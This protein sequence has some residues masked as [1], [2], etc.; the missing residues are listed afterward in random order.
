MA[1]ADLVKDPVAAVKR[2]YAACDLTVS[3]QFERALESHL[4]TRARSAPSFV[5][6]RRVRVGWRRRARAVLGL[7]GGHAGAG[8]W[9]CKRPPVG[10]VIETNLPSSL[11]D[12]DDDRFFFFFLDFF[13]CFFLRFFAGRASSSP[14]RRFSSARFSRR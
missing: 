12:D 9:L 14:A 2:V 1:Y 13:L 10:S 5:L 6:A 3:P 11:L 8:V 7:F 4:A